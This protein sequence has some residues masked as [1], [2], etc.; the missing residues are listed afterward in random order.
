M[1][2]GRSEGERFFLCS[3]PCFSMLLEVADLH[4]SFLVESGVVRAVDGISFS[5]STGEILGLVG[6][7]GCGKTVTALSIMRLLPDAKGVLLE[8]K[9]LLDG[10]DLLALDPEEMRRIRGKQISMIFQEPTTSLNP[11]FTVENQLGEVMRIHEGLDHQEARMKSLEMLKLVRLSDPERIMAEYPHRLSGGMSQRVMIAMALACNPR[12]LIADEPTTALD[13][14]IQAQILDLLQRLR[15]ELN[16][17]I[18]LITHD[19]GVIAQLAQ[20]VLVIYAGRVVEEA[21]VEDLFR[22]PSHPYTQ[23]LLQSIPPM[24]DE[25]AR[26]SRL[27]T[28]PGTVPNLLALPE[29]CKFHPRCQRKQEICSGKEPA[30]D[31]IDSGHRAR[32]YFPG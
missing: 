16:M 4:T 29:G 25:G 8:G 30:L 1:H 12:I 26:P 28:I 32:C 3:C 10:Q 23:G 13:V 24:R 6:E 2:D 31:P 7:S 17:A 5:L 15:D 18:I 20:R 27:F 19:L 14:T 9:V 21:S 11:V 22:L